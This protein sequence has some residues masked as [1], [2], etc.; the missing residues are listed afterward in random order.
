MSRWNVRSL[1]SGMTPRASLSDRARRLTDLV[2]RAAGVRTGA[3][4][5][6]L[7]GFETLEARAMLDGDFGSAVAISIDGLTQQGFADGDINP[8]VPGSNNDYYSFVAPKD[9]F[10]SVL[11]DT[12]SISPA[13]TLNTRLSIFSDAD[14]TNPITTG[15]NNGQLTTGLAKD[16]WAGFIAEAGQTYFVVVSNDGSS[17]NVALNYRVQVNAQ[18]IPFDTATDTGIAQE[19]GSPP[20]NPPAVPITPILGQLSRLEEDLLYTFNV[21]TDSNFNSLVTINAQVTQANLSI[22]LDSRVDVYK[23]SSAAGA[24][25]LVASDSDAGRL[26]DAF[27][28]LKV[29][30]GEVYYIRVRSDEINPG[31]EAFATGPVWLV[32]DASAEDIFMNPITRRGGVP[33]GAFDGFGDPTTPPTPNVPDPTFQTALWR[34]RAQGTG[35]AIITGIPTGLFPVTDPA[36]RLFDASGNLIAFNDNFAGASAQIQFQLIG[37]RDYYVIIDGFEINSLVQYQLW[38]EANH[39]FSTTVGIDDHLNTSDLPPMA[40]ANDTANDLAQQR[41]LET[42]TPLVFGPVFPTLDGDQNVVRDRGV[43]TEALG[44][45]RIHQAGDTDLFQFTPPVDMLGGYAGDNDDAGT[46]LFMGGRFDTADPNTPWPVGSRNVTI[47]DAADYWFTGAQF[48]DAA[49]NVTYGFNDN[50]NTPGTTGPEIYAMLDYDPGVALQGGTPPQ[51]MTRRILVVGGDFDLVVPSPFGPVHFLNLAVWV[52]DFNTGTF[53]WNSLGDADGPV[54][55]LA[56]YTPDQQMQDP[57]DPSQ[58]IPISRPMIG[59]TVIP[60]LAVGGDFTDIGGTAIANLATFDAV[61]GWIPIGTGTDG[62]VRALTVYDPPDPGAERTYQAANPPDPELR[63][64]ANTPDIPT[65]LIVGGEFSTFDGIA[66]DNIGLWTGGDSRGLASGRR[67]PIAGDPGTPPGPG[68]GGTEPAPLGTNGPVLSLVAYNPP[69]PD[70]AGPLQAPGPVLAIGGDFTLVD[71]LTRADP[72]ANPANNLAVTG[73]VTWGWIGGETDPQQPA[74]APYLG[75]DKL[76]FDAAGAIIYALTTW[77]P[78]ELNG[79]TNVDQRFLVL[80]G[81]F[82]FN[83]QA[84]LIA[85]DGNALPPDG[86][87]WG[88]FSATAGPDLPVRALTTVIDVQEPGIAANLRPSA[89]MP[90][91]VLYA[92]G[93]FTQVNNGQQIVQASRVVQYSAFRGQLADFFAFSRMAN[94]VD[95]ADPNAVPASSVFALSA[96]DDGNPLEWDR[97]DRPATRV[98]IV[99][100]PVEGSF[101]NTRVRVFS[102]D[103]RVM[104]N[105]QGPGIVYGFDKPGSETIA[106]PFPDPSG[107]LDPSLTAPG[108]IGQLGGIPVWGGEVYY[109]EVSGVGTGR[110]TVSVIVDGL[111]VDLNGDGVLDDVNA[112]M[113]EE[114]NEG[115]FA[116]A[117]RI[118]TQLANG[119][120][121]NFVAA[122][123]QPLHGNRARA[124]RIAPK[125]PSRI[126]EVGD[127]GVINAIDDTDLWTFRAEFTGTVEVRLT[128]TRIGASTGGTAFAEQ[129]DDLTA[130]T[131]EFTPQQRSLSSHLDGAIRIFRN[132]FEQIGYTDDNSAIVGGYD[133]SAIGTLNGEFWR[134]DPRIVF[135]VVAGNNYFIQVESSQQW[136]IAA[137][138]DAADRT[139][140]I[141]REIDRRYATGAYELFVNQMPQ[142]IIDIDNGQEVQDDHIDADATLA[143]PIAIADDP[144]DSATNGQGS[145]LGNINNTPNHPLDLDLFQFIAPGGGTATITVTPLGSPATLRPSLQ[146]F[147][148]QGNLIGTGTPIA[149]NAVRFTGP[150]IAGQRVLLRVFGAGQSE[151]DYRIDI[152]GLPRLDDIADNAKLGSAGDIP[153]QDFLGSGVVSGSIEAA[154]DTDILRFTT[155]QYQTMTIFGHPVDAT[156]NMAMTVYEVSEDP[157]GNPILLRIGKSV[158]TGAGGDVQ[159]TFSVA[160]NRRLDPPLADPA[161]EYPYYYVVVS[162]QNPETH[163]G[164]YTVTINFPPSDDHADGDTNADSVYD[165]GEFNFATEIPIDTATGGGASSGVIE[166]ASDSDLFFF[167]APA[168]GQAGVLV[169]RI[170][171]STLR[172]MVTVLDANA[173]TIA[174]ATADDDASDADVGVTFN[175]VR[176]MRYWVV[177]D[178]GTPNVNTTPIGG[179]TVA[180]TAPPIDDYA[181]IGEF[182]LAGTITLSN[183]TGVGRIGGTQAGDPSN[184]TINP[185]VDTDLFTFVVIAAG[186][187]TVTVTPF[188]S[189][190]GDLAVRISLFNTAGGAPFATADSPSQGQ[191]ASFTIT[192]ATLGQRYYILV[193]PLGAGDPTGEYAIEVAGP[194]PQ[195]NPPPTDPGAVDFNNPRILTLSPRTGDGSL[196]DT[197]DVVGDRDLFTFTTANSGRVFLDLLAPPGSLLRASIRVLSAANENAGSTVVFDG[198]GIPGSIASVSFV[199]AAN[200]QYWVIVDGLGDSVGAYMLRA[201]S[202]PVTQQLFFPEGFTSDSIRE[203]VSIINPND[204]D[205]TYTV[206]LRYEFGQAETVIA[207]GVVRAHSRDG[208][209]VNDATFYRSPGVVAGTPYSIVLESSLPLGAT[210]AHYDFGT[211]IGD[212]F[213]ED[214]SAAWNFARI[215]RD[216]GNVR[217]FIVFYNPNNF[218]ISVTLTAWQNGQQFGITRTFGALRRGGFALNDIEGF[219]VGV[220]SATLTAQ[221]AGPGNQANFIGI[222]ASLSHYDTGRD[223][224]FAALG[225][226][227]G[228]SRAGVIP[229]I[230]QGPSV[231]SEL[232]FYNPGSSPATL[233]LSGTYIRAQLPQLTRILSVAP[234]S[235]VVLSGADLGISDDQPVGLT[236]T[237]DV[238]VSAQSFEIQLGDGDGSTPA[239]SAATRFY[240]GDAFI[241]TTRAGSLYFEN[242]YLANPTAIDTTL[243]VTLEFLNGDRSTFSVPVSARGFAEVRLH[244]RLEILNRPDTNVWYAI[245]VSGGLPF[246]AAMTHYDLVLGGGWETNGVPFGLETALTSIP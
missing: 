85:T 168:S 44:E 28:T 144:A 241:D 13:S 48:F 245:D 3:S 10:V 24:V 94:G 204:A 226:P 120:A 5:V 96:F 26:N 62:P 99:V 154:G 78:P 211:S 19:A 176:G 100:Q 126:Q 235:Q 225:D 17:G 114:P 53:A 155:N 159:A 4:R 81:D 56:S 14:H 175:V 45:G 65:S 184:P 101:L 178:H 122:N 148:E 73:F 6:Q 161:R 179:Y 170:A 246:I 2:G 232:V 52:Q 82:T 61:D 135:N 145:I 124:Q 138:S 239:T 157:A 139:A 190:L 223:A 119:D 97:H 115:Q 129:I 243:V 108:A 32:I 21:P 152:A 11:A 224:G 75:T 39:T 165:T 134:R 7:M 244:E 151:G 220:F 164:R 167:T 41:L 107:M 206:V 183:T 150:I 228:G 58:N 191:P 31:R 207:N 95:F 118:N 102:S 141:D 189:G 128:T 149:N 91:E 105:G 198:S 194:A 142:Q 174:T 42:A 47:W 203:F 132:D 230:A 160:P 69:D 153:I 169:Q 71:G 186:D 22:R 143:T 111:P 49:N 137:P 66:L 171:G 64:V 106:P 188:S 57:T 43:R 177:V 90:Q 130:G 209:T 1:F 197:I 15:A 240:F 231:D 195:Q 237:S 121:D 212:S 30:P 27:T 116:Q 182:S 208:L 89:Q 80:G 50:T 131:S 192:G 34:F 88:W 117:I 221:A 70:G 104:T 59:S 181:N 185:G 213:T 72:P 238:P 16:G 40:D 236:Y 103:F 196:N 110:Y 123:T 205:A 147:D 20:P 33:G 76:G 222:V 9:G 216:P 68:F 229:N 86:P 214:L 140:N 146:V 35:L 37:G 18:N 109:V 217:D 98:A 180:V 156:L 55:A 166:I 234:H 127:M 46:A 202:Q 83:G 193:E 63:Y 187:H 25:T 12:R 218:D 201:N 77:N 112:S 23:Q 92:G 93:D 79:A 87:A 136:K 158:P 162:G 51:G 125:A 29:N 84:N 242:L 133:L 172:P 74:Y 233:T 163:F 219:P 113:A 227:A 199:A 200:T 36:L 60:Y 173:A 210:L 38:V 54:Y 215:E 8:S 67:N